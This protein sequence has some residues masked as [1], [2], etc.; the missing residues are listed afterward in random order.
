MPE[1]K[2]RIISCG[3][4]AEYN[5]FHN[6]H[7][8]HLQQTRM[9]LP[10][11]VIIAVLSANFVQRGLP[12][13]I[14][15]WARAKMALKNGVDLVLEL[16]T[17]FSCNSGMVFAQGAVDTLNAVGASFISFGVE[18]LAQSENF[19]VSPLNSISCILSQESVSFKQ[20]VK[21][22]LSNGVSYSKAVAAALEAES[23]GAG[24]YASKPNNILALSYLTHIM[25][26]KYPID[27]LPI[28]RCGGGH[29][30]CASKIRSIIS[31]RDKNLFDLHGSEKVDAELNSF[32]PESSVE[33][34]NDCLKNGRIFND[35]FKLFEFIRFMFLSSDKETL[36][37]ITGME[38]GLY[39]L[40]AGNIEKSESYDDLIGRCVCA[41]YTRSRL[42]RQM[43]RIMLGIDKWTDLAIQRTG[44][45]YARVLGYN[46]AGKKYLREI[47]KTAK[48]S[49]VTRLAAVKEPLGRLIAQIEY[50]ASR[51]W[52]LVSDSRVNV[53]E[54]DTKPIDFS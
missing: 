20:A 49:I 14:D 34:M 33:I 53:R 25:R 3:I 43:I 31:S 23:A 35:T 18:D 22:A 41:R 46:G 32:L 29:N 36:G 8:R 45:R 37:R 39:G 21:H 40:F 52:E 42:Q 51:L 16:P 2:K 19:S 10:D 12:S 54:A 15:K 17:F 7:L 48:L 38:E 9:K 11:A 27:P 24:E 47:S 4:A 28:K 1:K 50:K 5:P 30:E 6:G 13:F 26:K 44:A